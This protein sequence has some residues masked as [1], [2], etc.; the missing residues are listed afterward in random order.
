MEQFIS[1]QRQLLVAKNMFLE[2]DEALIKM[3]NDDDQTEKLFTSIGLMD[4][5]NVESK[6]LQHKLK[7]FRGATEM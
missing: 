5:E 6:M 1:L 7:E 4:K 2:N 3:L